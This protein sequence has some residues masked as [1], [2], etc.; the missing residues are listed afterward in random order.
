M[1]G[2]LTIFS[3]FC[4]LFTVTEAARA[5]HGDPYFALVEVL[6]FPSYENATSAQKSRQG[7]FSPNA[8]YFSGIIADRLEDENFMDFIL[9][10]GDDL[11]IGSPEWSGPVCNKTI[12]ESEETRGRFCHLVR[13]W[14][15]MTEPSMSSG[16]LAAEAYATMGANRKHIGDLVN[17]IPLGKDFASVAMGKFRAVQEEMF[18]EGQCE[19]T[20]GLMDGIQ[21]DLWRMETLLQKVLDFDS[22]D[23]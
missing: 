22:S 20:K 4:L 15:A 23:L 21:N 5:K 17:P 8:V 1:F 6:S 9:R 3:C 19:A 13:V 11:V 16:W 10:S 18:G 12:D 7:R 14:A 2:A